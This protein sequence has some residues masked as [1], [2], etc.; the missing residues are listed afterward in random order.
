MKLNLHNN[1]ALLNRKEGGLSFRKLIDLILQ[2]NE[3]T[4][5]IHQSLQLNWYYVLIFYIVILVRKFV[6]KC[7]FM[8]EKRGKINN[9]TFRLEYFFLKM[10]GKS[11]QDTTPTYILLFHR[12]WKNYF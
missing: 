9:S 8:I 2:K 3:N 7:F 12:I 11:N 5:F 1:H 10:R 6:M 4:F